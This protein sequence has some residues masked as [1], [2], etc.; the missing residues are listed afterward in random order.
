MPGFRQARVFPPTIMGCL[1]WP[2]MF[3]SGAATGIGPITI[4]HSSSRPP[5]ILLGHLI[6]S[7]QRSR[8]SKNESNV[9]GRIS[10]QTSI[11]RG[12]WLERAEKESPVP[13]Q[14]TLVFAVCDLPNNL[15]PVKTTS[16]L[17]SLVSPIFSVRLAL[18]TRPFLTRNVG[19]ELS[20][21]N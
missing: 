12:T 9:A 17:K 19:S 11:V 7:I 20:S 5:E 16:F 6:L 14:T 13:V 21:P 8:A 18:G 10:A 4:R 2:E 3:G 15:K 1:I